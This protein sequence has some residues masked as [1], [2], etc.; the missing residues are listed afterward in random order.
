MEKVD[1]ITV[2]FRPGIHAPISLLALRLSEDW[3]CSLRV[4]KMSEE[5]KSAHLLQKVRG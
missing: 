5:G 4:M 1:V 2:Y 3:K